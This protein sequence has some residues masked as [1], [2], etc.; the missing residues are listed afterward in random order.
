M[1]PSVCVFLLCC[2]SFFSQAQINVKDSTTKPKVGFYK[3]IQQFREQTP[4]LTNSV[5]IDT[6]VYWPNTDSQFVEYTYHFLDSTKNIDDWMFLYD[7]R[8]LYRP[9]ADGRIHQLHGTGLF[10]YYIY[11]YKGK[12]LLIWGVAAT[13]VASLGVGLLD[14]LVSGAKPVLVYF[15][16]KGELVEALPYSFAKFLK[17]D[18]DLYKEFER[19]RKYKIKDFIRYLDKMN[20][21]YPL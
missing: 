3:T 21:R 12:N 1:K 16:R 4:F 17:P 14:E 6:V 20:A 5:V 10:P 15:N 11:Y 7:G 18:A 9:I 2:L 13:G 8:N 19:E